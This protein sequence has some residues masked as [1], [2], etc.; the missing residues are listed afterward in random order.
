MLNWLP[1][2]LI[3]RVPGNHMDINNIQARQETHDGRTSKRELYKTQSNFASCLS[4]FRNQSPSPPT[5]LPMRSTTHEHVFLPFERPFSQDPDGLRAN[6]LLTQFLATCGPAQDKPVRRR[7]WP[8]PVASTRS[9]V[10]FHAPQRLS[11]CLFAQHRMS[12]MCEA[13]PPSCCATRKVSPYWKGLAN[14]H[15]FEMPRV[16]SQVPINWFKTAMSFVLSNCFKVLLLRCIQNVYHEIITEKYAV[17]K[18]SCGKH[19]QAS[20]EQNRPLLPQ[21]PIRL[22]AEKGSQSSDKN[23]ASVESFKKCFLA[24]LQ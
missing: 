21:E 11:H 19:R 17:I 15:A 12:R 5:C 16:A 13:K 7:W 1:E 14:H 2:Y 10:D 6:T 24:G 20:P 4:Y 18:R 8:S 22:C 3:F 23:Q 9:G